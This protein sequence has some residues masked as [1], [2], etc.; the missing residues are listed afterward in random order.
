MVKLLATVAVP[1]SPGVVYGAGHEIDVTD[2]QAQLLRMHGKAEAMTGSGTTGGGGGAGE[3]GSSHIT[4]MATAPTSTTCT[5][6]WTTDVLSDSYVGYGKNNSNES[7]KQDNTHMVTAHSIQ[8]TGLSPSTLYHYFVRS[9][10][11]GIWADSVDKTFTTT[12]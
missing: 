12:A 8:L 2:A 1:D 7:F 11:G 10:A 5:I 6:T 9:M 4:D 3:S